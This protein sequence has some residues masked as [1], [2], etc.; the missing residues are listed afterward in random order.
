M[1]LARSKVQGRAGPFTAST[2]L[3][4]PKKQAVVADPDLVLRSWL[5]RYIEYSHATFPLHRLFC[6]QR[7]S[8]DDRWR[9]ARELQ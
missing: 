2:T 9:D 1:H 3:L 4:Y 7:P 8:L 5:S 6:G